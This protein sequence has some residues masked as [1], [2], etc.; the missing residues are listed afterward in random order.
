MI[1]VTRNGEQERDSNLRTGRQY[2]P[3]GFER[4]QDTLSRLSG[5]QA[6]P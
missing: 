3:A 2:L 1:M 6:H 5:L 4:M